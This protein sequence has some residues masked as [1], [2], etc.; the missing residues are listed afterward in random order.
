MYFHTHIPKTAGTFLNLVF[1]A[2]FGCQYYQAP[3]L[4]RFS[5]K[6]DA[7]PGFQNCLR[8]NELVNSPLFSYQYQFVSSHFLLPTPEMLMK[9]PNAHFICAVRDPVSRLVSDYAH[10]CALRE[11]YVDFPQWVSKRCNLQTAMLSENLDI[12]AIRELIVQRRI[13]IVRTE[14]VLDDLCRNFGFPP[15]TLNWIKTLRPK[16]VNIG[17]AYKDNAKNIVSKLSSA[18]LDSIV[19]TD[20]KLISLINDLSIRPVNKLNTPAT[21]NFQ[22]NILKAK[23]LS[24]LLRKLTSSAK[25]R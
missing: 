24:F 17:A 1:R 3:D 7:C 15:K 11:Q 18:E 6:A 2:I 16:N 14:H 20:Q 5:K 10:K 19:G 22:I 25:V 21:D 12:T 13:V 9:F 4:K 23:F 8:Y